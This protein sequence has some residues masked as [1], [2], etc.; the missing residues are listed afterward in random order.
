MK[1]FNKII[2]Y[3]LMFA[4][5][6]TSVCHGISINTRAASADANT[7]IKQLIVYYRDY[8]EQAATD[9]ER[10]LAE[11]KQVDET[12]YEAWRQIMDYWSYANTDM[13]V[14]I[15]VAPDGLPDDDSVCIVILGLALNSN[16]TMKDELIGRLQVG[17]ATANKYPNSYVVVT[18]GGTASGNPNV[19][20]GGLMGDWL[21]DQ[22]LDPDRLIVENKAPDTV[23]N[24]KNTFAILNEQYPSVK[25]LIMITSDYH[26]PRGSILFYSKCLLSAYESGSEPLAMI[27]NAGYNTGSKGY[28]T[29]PLQANGVAS[30]AGVSLSG[31]SVELSQVNGLIIDQ[32]IPYQSGGTLNLNVQAVYNSGFQRD[33]SDSVTITD[34]DPALGENQT[35]TVS[36]SENGITVSGE[37]NLRETHAEYNDNTYVKDKIAQV[38]AMNLSP[39]T[40]S[41]VA[42]I[43]NALR[44][45]KAVVSKEHATTD[46][47]KAAYD[48]LNDALNRLIKRINIALKMN[49]E[50]NCNAADASKITDGTISTNNYWASVN[51][52]GNVASVDAEIIID[53]DGLYDVDCVQ[54]YPYWGGSRIYKYELFGSSDKDNWVKIGENISDDY[55]T[56]AGFTHAMDER[57]RYVKLKGIS[58]K[59]AGRDDIN[60]IHIIE[61]QVYGEEAN[62]FA[63]GKPTSS[64]GTDT[65]AGS[66]SGS[67]EALVVD[68]DRSTYWDGGV[69]ANAPW[70]TI[71]MQDV[72]QVEQVNVITY[73]MRTDNRYYYYDIYTSIDG[74]EFT[75]VYSKTDGTDKATIYGDM[76]DISDQPLYARYVKVVGTYDSANPS[77]HLNEVRVYGQEIDYEL[78][79]AKEDLKQVIADTRQLDVSNRTPQSVAALTKALQDGDAL[80]VSDSA[81]IA[82]VTAGKQ[83]IMTAIQGLEYREADYRAVDA[84]IAKVPADL[85]LYTEESVQVL[86]LALDAVVQHK[87]ILEQDVVDRYAAMIENALRGLKRKP[88]GTT[89]ALGILE[90]SLNDLQ[91][92]MSADTKQEIERYLSHGENVTV[93]LQEIRLTNAQLQQDFETEAALVRLFGEA[94]HLQVGPFYDLRILI[95][96]Q[97][98]VIDQ[99]TQTKQP[100]RMKLMIPNELKKENRVFYVLRHH[101]HVVEVLTTTQDDQYL[102]F[103][104]DRFSVYTIGYRDE[105]T[106]QPDNP[107]QPKDPNVNEDKPVNPPYHNDQSQDKQP[108]AQTPNT[109]DDTQPFVW[110]G[111]ML[112]AGFA[113]VRLHRKAHLYDLHQ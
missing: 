85:A 64:S 71:D 2:K 15:G 39:Y 8:Q 67:N 87:S 10:V 26:V 76:I 30:V 84:A 80:L 7:Y 94:M 113:V 88:R 66:S 92:N 57:I 13:K 38:E 42:R 74:K 4:I 46:E 89:I 75:Q 104:T 56:S 59:V 54:V 19:T 22:G 62:N 58:T 109:G 105:S 16:G 102:S 73:W 35:I 23:G 77:F 69:Y 36:Y 70:V 93:E 68:G 81:L 51:G 110:L 44:D 83:A 28:E 106:T 41:S 20:E 78:I 61:M 97:D 63:Y 47:L 29:I 99:I 25:S 52:S 90:N 86:R 107:S 48:A 72:Y 27:S 32:P 45:A 40:R 34:F 98:S 9:I 18:G 33:V 55:A 111:L 100:L 103:E 31:V 3:I 5:C 1:G 112:A 24:A 21:L 79:L 11:L 95:K 96:H 91:D 60:N 108:V 6:F 82:D 17:L 50:T 49:V 12:K 65:S 101:D 37:L 53:L 14:N 43:Q